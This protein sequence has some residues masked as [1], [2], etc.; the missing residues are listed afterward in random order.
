MVGKRKVCR[1]RH[2][3]TNPFDEANKSLFDTA[4]LIELKTGELEQAREKYLFA[5]AAYEHVYSR[6]LLATKIKEPDMVQSEII[7]QAKMLSY[8]SKLEMIKTESTYRRLQ[9]EVKSLRDRLDVWKEVSYNLR[10]DRVQG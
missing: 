9:N 7:A 1:R 10:R 8:E 3:I 5:E 4:E 2:L 6:F